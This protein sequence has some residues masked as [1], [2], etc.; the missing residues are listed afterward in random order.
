V[1]LR[2]ATSVL[3]VLGASLG[4]V[5]CAGL[6]PLTPVQ[7]G[8]R[9]H[10]EELCRQWFPQGAWQA[11]HVMHLK[12]PLGPEGVFLGA[13]AVEAGQPETFRGVLM[14]QEGFVLLDLTDGPGGL[15]VHRAVGPLSKPGY[16]TSMAADIRLLLV[17]PVGSP[18]EVGQDD[19]GATVCRYGVPPGYVQIAVQGERAVVSRLDEGGAVLREGVL[20]G[21]DERGF[22]RTLTLQSQGLFG[23]WLQLQL[24]DGTLAS[25]EPAAAATAGESR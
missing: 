10:A 18:L 12:P 11:T 23:Y 22:A 15:K 9:A 13:V 6:A 14:S 20:E 19:E 8:A 7:A 16:A 4:A 2:R 17:P 24:L 5:A 21:K 25:A 1:S 3:L